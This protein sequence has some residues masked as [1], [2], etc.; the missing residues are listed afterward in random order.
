MSGYCPG[1]G[2]YH[3]EDEARFCAKCSGGGKCQ[4]V[5]MPPF[6]LSPQPSEDTRRD[7]EIAG[8]DMNGNGPKVFVGE[9]RPALA[10]E[11]WPGFANESTVEVF[12]ILE[13]IAEQDPL[14]A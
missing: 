5:R 10:A 9:A 8:L 3:E 1:C 14:I 2:S 7:L 11:P 12:D 13:C 4:L 6:G